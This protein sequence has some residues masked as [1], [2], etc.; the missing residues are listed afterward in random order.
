[1]G[2]EEE[3]IIVSKLSSLIKGQRAFTGGLLPAQSAQIVESVE[4]SRLHERSCIHAEYDYIFC[5]LVFFGRSYACLLHFATCWHT[6]LT[7][8]S[9][10]EKPF[11]QQH[12]TVVH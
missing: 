5:V 8:R 12:D 2:C 11:K 6:C 4:T 9:L 3:I 1:M 10:P 7:L